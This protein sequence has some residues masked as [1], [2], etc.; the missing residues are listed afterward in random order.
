MC[1]NL[2]LIRG[3]F[4]LRPIRYLSVCLVLVAN[5]FWLATRQLSKALFFAPRA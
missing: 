4:R 1:A 2:Y 3:E 5:Y